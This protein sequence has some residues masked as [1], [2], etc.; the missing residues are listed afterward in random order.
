M[1]ETIV[2]IRKWASISWTLKMR[3]GMRSSFSAFLGVSP[4]NNGVVL[5]VIRSG[6]VVEQFPSSFIFDD[7]AHL[8]PHLLGIVNANLPPSP[9]IVVIIVKDNSTPS[10]SS[11]LSPSP[12]SSLLVF[13][14]SYHHSHPP[15]SDLQT[16]FAELFR[17]AILRTKL[18]FVKSR[19]W[20]RGVQGHRRCWS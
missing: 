4:D 13:D 8:Q 19:E 16:S 17:V 20:P 10:S 5:V 6:L 11:T 3:S 9:S 12:P 14:S 1:G 15:V 18:L 2:V 7:E